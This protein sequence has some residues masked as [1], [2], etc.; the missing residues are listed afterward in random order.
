[1]SDFDLYL[2]IDYSG[3]QTPTSR[4]NNLQVYAAKPAARRVY[5]GRV[6]RGRSHIS[7]LDLATDFGHAPAESKT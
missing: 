3:A 1:M 5:R 2:G 7:S 4:L 6:Y